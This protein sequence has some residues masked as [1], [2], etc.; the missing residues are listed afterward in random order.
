MPNDSVLEGLLLPE[1]QVMRVVAP[2]KAGRLDLYVQK[3][4]PMEVCPRCACPATAVYDRR[5]VTV[6]DAPLRARYVYLHIH[7]RRFVCSRCRRPFTEPVAG[8][9]KG[10]RTTERFRKHLGPPTWE[11]LWSLG[12]HTKAGVGATFALLL[13]RMS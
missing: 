13:R 8:I 5:W 11:G 10:A 7:K 6:R 1:T 3:T 4:S 12:F 2:K 9:Q